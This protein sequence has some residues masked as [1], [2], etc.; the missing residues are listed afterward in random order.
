[1]AKTSKHG[2]RM[3]KGGGKSIRSP[4]HKAYDS[5]YGDQKSKDKG[6]GARDKRLSKEKL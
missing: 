1:M 6:K 3:A 5:L 4:Q 2:H